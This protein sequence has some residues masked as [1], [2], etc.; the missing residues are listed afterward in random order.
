MD[1]ST[2]SASRLV[3][4][5]FG[6]YRN[7]MATILS[8]QQMWS[9]KV[10]MALVM[11]VCYHNSIPM[12]KMRKRALAAATTAITR[13]PSPKRRRIVGPSRESCRESLEDSAEGE[14][15]WR[16]RYDKGRTR[17]RRR[18]SADCEG[19]KQLTTTAM[20]KRREWAGADNESNR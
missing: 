15:R 12:T 5:N 10:L 8:A 17:R 18:R 14:D 16:C 19:N 11:L 13:C 9:I 20:G 6:K 2:S 3:L 1:S 7:T 4:L